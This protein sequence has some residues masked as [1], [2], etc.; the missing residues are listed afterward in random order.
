MRPQMVLPEKKPTLTPLA[1]AASM[2]WYIS[3]E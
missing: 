1:T 2:F 3:I